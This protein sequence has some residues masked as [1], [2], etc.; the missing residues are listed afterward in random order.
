MKTLII[1]GAIATFSAVSWAADNRDHAAASEVRPLAEITATCVACHGRDGNAADGPHQAMNPRLAGQY[2][3]FLAKAL[4]EY[5]SGVR[6]SPIMMG[7]VAGLNDE[8]INRI[9]EHYAA[10]PG[11]LFTPL[12]GD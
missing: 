5:R 6:K 1:A 3:D 7:M 8:E 4:R 12:L 10:Q 11:K 2:A 9:A